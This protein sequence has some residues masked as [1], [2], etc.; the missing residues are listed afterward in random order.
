MRAL[1]QRKRKQKKNGEQRKTEK[2]KRLCKTSERK[3][4]YWERYTIT[5]GPRRCPHGCRKWQSAELILHLDSERLVTAT[6]NILTKET[7]CVKRTAK[8]T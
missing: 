7:L 6:P 3:R 4:V 8:A 1:Q 2:K 5:G